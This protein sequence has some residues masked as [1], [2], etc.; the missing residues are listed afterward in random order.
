[1]SHANIDTKA[2]RTHLGVGQEAAAPND[3]C[4]VLLER[5]IS[6]ESSRS[7]HVDVTILRE[8]E[9]ALEDAGQYQRSFE[10]YARGNALVRSS[11][12]YR[13][14][15]MRGGLQRR[16]IRSWWRPTSCTR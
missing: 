3:A 14:E 8:L 1:M 15:V 11:I 16:G 13:P 10:H 12:V 4:D 7:A 6:V 5:R 9:K 2:G